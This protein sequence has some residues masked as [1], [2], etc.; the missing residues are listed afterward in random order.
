VV[1]EPVVDSPMTMAA[2]PI[3]GSPMAKIN[4]EEDHVFQES[5]ANYEEEQQEPPMQDV[6]HDEPCRRSQ[7]TRRSAISDD[8]EVDIRE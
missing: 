6:P 3:V 1:V 2:T 7:R 4:E 5:I 8:F